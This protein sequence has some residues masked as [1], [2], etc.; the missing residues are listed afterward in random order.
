[1]YIGGETEIGG[2]NSKILKRK[3]AGRRSDYIKILIYVYI[4]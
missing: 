1:L 3:S 4:D 2:K